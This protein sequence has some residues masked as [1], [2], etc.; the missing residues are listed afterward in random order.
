MTEEP[1]AIAPS[2]AL[3]GESRGTSEPAQP[4]AAIF[5]GALAGALTF[6]LC[7]LWIGPVAGIL[8]AL[9]ATLLVLA[10]RNALAA[11]A[12]VAAG[13]LAALALRS[14]TR[15]TATLLASACFAAGLAVATRVTPRSRALRHDG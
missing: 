8:I 2:E 14:S 10:H 12:F 7:T 13:A 15:A 5:V 4:P 3:T 9:V 11:I 1:A 6:A